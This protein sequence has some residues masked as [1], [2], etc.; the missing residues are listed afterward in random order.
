M[1]SNCTTAFQFHQNAVGAVPGPFDC[2]LTLRGIRTLAVRMRQ[3]EQNALL[4]AAFL[5]KHPQ[6]E[7]VIYPGLPDHPQHKLA[8]RQMT[9]FGAIVTFRIKGGLEAANAFVK[10]LTVFIF[11]ERPWRR[12]IAC[13]SSRH[14]EPC[15]PE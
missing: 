7:S 1:T 6:V 4:I 11:A 9:G 15:D 13:L 10:A 3:H 14:D 8:Q 2:W 5:A 12:R